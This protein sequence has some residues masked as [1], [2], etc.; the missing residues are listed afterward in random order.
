MLSAMFC[1]RTELT[2]SGSV[3]T[4]ICS[5]GSIAAIRSGENDAFE[6][7]FMAVSSSMHEN[8]QIRDPLDCHITNRL[9]CRMFPYI[10]GLRTELSP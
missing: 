6:K 7:S 4:A 3:A 9:D 1:T 5:A 2:G 10:F 8:P